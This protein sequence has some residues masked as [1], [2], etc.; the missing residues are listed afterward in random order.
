MTDRNIFQALPE[1]L[2]REVVGFAMAFAG[3][4]T[5]C[6]DK[7]IRRLLSSC[8]LTCKAW[9]V[10][11]RPLLFKHLTLRSHDDVVELGK[12][13]SSAAPV[14]QL[15]IRHLELREVGSL[16]PWIYV[17]PHLFSSAYPLSPLLPCTPSR[18]TGGAAYLPTA[19]TPLSAGCF[20]CSVLVCRRSPTSL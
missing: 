4:G 19:T 9:M 7:Q 1:E 3:H 8:S 11:F 10:L 12:L 17:V 14:I 6:P 15:Y 2:L 18:A 5:S 20:R 16:H 13:L